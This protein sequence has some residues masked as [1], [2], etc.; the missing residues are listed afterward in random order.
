M[1]RSDGAEIQ[2]DKATGRLDTS[3]DKLAMPYA[4]SLFVKEME[5]AHVEM[6][7]LTTERQ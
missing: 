2:F 6:K 4:M 7:L 5:S 3:P 1:D